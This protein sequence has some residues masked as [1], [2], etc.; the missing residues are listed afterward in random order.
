M[1]ETY[2]GTPVRE[3]LIRPLMVGEQFKVLEDTAHMNNSNEFMRGKA[4]EWLTVAYIRNSQFKRTHR[5]YYNPNGAVPATYGI[6][7]LIDYAVDEHEGFF[8]DHWLSYHMNI[9]ETNLRLIQTDNQLNQKRLPN[10]PSI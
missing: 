2:R 10:L 3:R 5:A 6:I 9:Y 8:I 1:I 4:S 7:P